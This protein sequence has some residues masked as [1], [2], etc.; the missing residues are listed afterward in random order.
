M[1]LCLGLMGVFPYQAL[2][3]GKLGYFMR[4]CGFNV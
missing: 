1:I 4:I 2:D 3:M